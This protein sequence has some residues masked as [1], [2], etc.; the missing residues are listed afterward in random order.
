MAVVKSVLH[1]NCSGSDLPPTLIPGSDEN[2]CNYPP[3]DKPDASAL[4]G[5]LDSSF[6]ICY[7]I[8]MF[9]SGFIAERVSLRY[10]L[11]LG[12]LFSGF[13]C[14]AFGYAKVNDIH[15]LLY[16][17]VVQGL[18]GIFQTTGW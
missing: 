10:F 17:M 9:F 15:S 6:L 1:R 13:F 16:F 4:L 3:F 14:Y 18:A 2:S 12:M 8:A 11:S 5:F 7:A